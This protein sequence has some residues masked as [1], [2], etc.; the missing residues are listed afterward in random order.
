MG[1]R[2]RAALIVALLI[3]AA[4][5]IGWLAVNDKEPRY[6]GRPLTYWVEA[7]ASGKENRAHAEEAIQKIGTNAFPSVLR[8][9]RSPE[10]KYRKSLRSL[11]EK[12]PNAL[13]PKWA[14]ED[15]IAPAARAMIAIKALGHRAHLL[16]PELEG[17]AAD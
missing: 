11:A 8:W 1:V 9:I 15:Y 17:I 7:L 13:R 5:L 12:L 4:V 16:V 10:P 2:P 14:R 3:V 6:D